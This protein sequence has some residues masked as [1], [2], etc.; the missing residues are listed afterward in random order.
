M[1]ADKDRGIRRQKQKRAK[2]NK[3]AAKTQ[4]PGTSAPAAPPKAAAKGT[5]KG[6]AKAGA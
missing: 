1:S 3:A 2:D 4:R 5:A 6:A